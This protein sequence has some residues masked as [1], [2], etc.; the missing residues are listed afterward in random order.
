MAKRS[1]SQTSADVDLPALKDD[2]KQI[3]AAAGAVAFVL[4]V[5]SLGVPAVVAWATEKLGPAIPIWKA[6]VATAPLTSSIALLG[7]AVLRGKLDGPLQFLFAAACTLAATA[8]VAHWVDMPGWIDLAARFHDLPSNP[9]QMS[10]AVCGLF[11]VNYWT[12]YGAELFGSS[13]VVGLFLA[14]AWGVKLLPHFDGRRAAAARKSAQS[15]QR[16]AA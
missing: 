5:F 16:R 6:L 8:A 12:I 7:V 11:L 1:G 2:L 10:A 13:V 3:T 4:S 15:P 9:I 14:W